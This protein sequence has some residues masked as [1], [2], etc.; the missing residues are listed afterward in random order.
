MEE[1]CNT[2]EVASI[3][4]PTEEAKVSCNTIGRLWMKYEG[5]AIKA[6]IH[7]L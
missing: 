1:V 6:Y 3:G 7:P 2:V 5:V 4:R